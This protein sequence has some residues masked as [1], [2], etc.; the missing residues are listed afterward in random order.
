[1]RSTF[2]TA[3]VAIALLLL[4]V[5]ATRA[6]PPQQPAACAPVVAPVCALNNGYRQTY[7]NAC[8]AARDGAELLYTGE[9]R[10]PRSPGVRL[11]YYGLTRASSW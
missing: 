6:Q 5:V 4:P 8:L 11:P 1:M 9:C 2:R 10:I 7:W 3:I